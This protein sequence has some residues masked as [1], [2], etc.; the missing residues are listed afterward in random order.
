MFYAIGLCLLFTI[1]FVLSL[2]VWSSSRVRMSR[3]SPEVIYRR[4]V[5]VGVVSAVSYLLSGLSLK[6]VGFV[7]DPVSSV[8][9]ALSGLF[10]T[11]ILFLGPL[12][13]LINDFD[14]SDIPKAD[15][16][17]FRNLVVGPIAEEWVFRALIIPLLLKAGVS[18]F[19]T[20][21]LSMFFFAL[22]HLHHIYN[23][24]PFTVLFQIFYTSVFGAYSTF[25]FLRTG[26]L[27]APILSHVFCNYMGFP[28]LDLKHPKFKV[29]MV[30]F[31]LG[32]TSFF[33]LLIPLTDPA[34]HNS[35][36]FT[37]PTMT[38]AYPNATG[39]SHESETVYLFTVVVILLAAVASV[40]A[41]V[42][43]NYNNTRLRNKPFLI[44]EKHH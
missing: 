33:A 40:L 4:F 15:L 35:I 34:W 17:T 24:P 23:T 2:Y 26:N 41:K 16:I 27:F 28:H 7:S 38:H 32:L 10:L 43:V 9:S 18:M 31:V 44:N 36:Y 1:S 6:E 20:V 25:L 42:F 13:L 21:V 19:N 37:D 8:I 11:M 29:V 12:F 22:A 3:D 5:F 39:V 30:F 14:P